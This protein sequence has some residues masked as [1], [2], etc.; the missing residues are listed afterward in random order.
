MYTIIAL[1][2][3]LVM[4]S[5]SDFLDETTDKSGSAYIYHMDQLYG[6]T[7]SID[8]YLFERVDVETGEGRSSGA[9]LTEALP[10]TDAVELTPE[11][12]VHGLRASEPTTYESYCWQGETLMT[13]M[14]M[15]WTWTP[16]WERI[17]RFN[18]VLE[19]LDKVIQTTEAIHDQVEGEA[20]F[21]RAYY[22]FML[23]T[24]Y[25]LWGD[26][27]P[28]IGYRDNAT[29]GEVPE[30]KTVSYTLERIY[31]DLR[32]AEKALTKAW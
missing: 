5:C 19:Y 30:R 2:G 15:M 20:R 25:C 6:L 8:L 14:W 7:G 31:E 28:G 3:A 29:A 23:L 12:Y 10:L 1:L 26:D 9:Y 21:G 24:Q 32:L 22:H 13:S 18:T 11:F 16:V 4:A 27:K 17:Y